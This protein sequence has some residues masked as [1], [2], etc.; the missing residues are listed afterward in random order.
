MIENLKKIQDSKTIDFTK[1]VKVYFNFQ[2]KLWSIHQGTV[3]AHCNY[4]CMK[5]VVFK[6]SERGRQRTVR[7]QK[8]NVHAFVVGYIIFHALSVSA[9]NWRSVKYNPYK[10]QKFV[11]NEIEPVDSADFVDMLASSENRKVL[12]CNCR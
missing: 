9:D 2:K 5:D 3:K 10:N 1:P 7:N 4:L 8:K 12:A 11:I 6:V